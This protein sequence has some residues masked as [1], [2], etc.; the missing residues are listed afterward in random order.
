[1]SKLLANQRII[2][3]H[4][5]HRLPLVALAPLLWLGAHGQAGRVTGD[6][7]RVF[8]DPANDRMSIS[9]EDALVGEQG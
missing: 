7:L 6:G 9:V 2:D 5:M 1:M 4:R 3:L 8:P